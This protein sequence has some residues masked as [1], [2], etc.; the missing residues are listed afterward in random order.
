MEKHEKQKMY[1]AS[2][3]LWVHSTNLKNM[4]YIYTSNPETISL[5]QLS[6]KADSLLKLIEKHHAEIN[7]LI[8]TEA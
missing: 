6:L 3:D 7:E 4:I 1:Y 2:L 5:Q 8:N